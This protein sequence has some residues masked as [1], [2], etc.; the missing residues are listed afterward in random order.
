MATY[1]EVALSNVMKHSYTTMAKMK[2]AIVEKNDKIERAQDHEPID[3]LEGA[4]SITY[5]TRDIFDRLTSSQGNADLSDVDM[6]A[7]QIEQCIGYWAAY[8][9]IDDD[10]E[11]KFRALAQEVVAGY[12]SQ[13]KK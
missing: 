6:F 8:G 5:R 11:D 2:W 12:R 1:Q 7:L 3:E 9:A 4:I 13:I 10:E